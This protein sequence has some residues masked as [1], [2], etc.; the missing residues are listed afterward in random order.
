L[1]LWRE[2]GDDGES[3]AASWLAHLKNENQFAFVS[4]KNHQRLSDPTYFALRN[5][6]NTQFHLR[7]VGRIKL[8]VN[9]SLEF[10]K[11]Y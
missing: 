2:R 9:L 8:F 3:V 7:H 5:K 11:V 10:A 4:F 6:K 1:E